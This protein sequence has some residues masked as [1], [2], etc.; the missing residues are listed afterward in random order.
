LRAPALPVE[1][2]LVV[3][4]ELGAPSDGLG[5]AEDLVDVRWSRD[6]SRRSPTVM[7][8][9]GTSHLLGALDASKDFASSETA[10]RCCWKTRAKERQ[11]C[12][13]D[14]HHRPPRHVLKHAARR[15][16]VL[17]ADWTFEL[18]VYGD[19]TKMPQETRDQASDLC[20]RKPT[21]SI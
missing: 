14:A 18:R 19:S 4:I 1:D 9:A 15:F 12:A 20:K 13:G 3:L 6:F 2:L 7:Q 16:G 8:A 21:T 11:T 17:R 5:A 10:Q